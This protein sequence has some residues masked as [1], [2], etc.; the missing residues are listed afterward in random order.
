VWV[1]IG[2]L[3]S[4]ARSGTSIATYAA[5]SP[6]GHPICDEPFGPW[7]RTP[8]PFN[9]PPIQKELMETFAAQGHVFDERVEPLATKLFNQMGARTGSLI[10]KVPHQHPHP[11]QIEAF[12]PRVPRVLLIRN[13]LHRLNSFH[14]R[15]WTANAT[16]GHDLARYK[17]FA[18]RW[19]AEPPERRLVY[20]DIREDP[21]GFFR[22]M[23]EA[24]DWC[25]EEQDL[26][27][28]AAYCAE[29]YHH[30]S[31]RVDADADPSRVVSETRPA[32]PEEAVEAYLSDRFIVD[33]MKRLGW[34]TRAEDYV[35]AGAL[36]AW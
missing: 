14:A 7:D 5:A 12:Y 31:K 8:P 28:A 13:P 1:K 33:V 32:L 19:L 11:S 36:S 26:Q 9:H 25:Y 35:R 24:W 2:W 4:M 15:G 10:C 22:K 20:D 27:T 16:P 23:Y 6:W 21:V 30:R 29:H 3:F 18:A 17:A 34:S